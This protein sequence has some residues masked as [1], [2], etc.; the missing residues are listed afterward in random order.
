MKYQ[1]FYI[2][3]KTSYPPIVS[4]IFSKKNWW[5]IVLIAA[6]AVLVEPLII[7]RRYRNIPF[8][9]HSYLQLI[10]YLLFIAVPFFAFLFWINRREV[11][12]RKRGYGWE[13]KFEVT[14]KRSFF[15]FCY[16]W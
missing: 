7:Y 16:L 4:P 1:E 6:V 12:K 11:I 14:G 5:R 15:G 8:S 10:E 3:Y 2:K 9:L 13:G